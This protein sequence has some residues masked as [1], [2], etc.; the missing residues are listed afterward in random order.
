MKVTIVAGAR[1][2]FI[3]VAPI[4]KAI[5]KAQHSGGQI[6]YRLVHTGQHYDKKMSSDFFEQLNIS[7]PDVN[8]EAGGGTQAEQTAAIMIRF[9]KELMENRPDIVLVVGDVT[10]TMA[11]A[12]TAKKLGI[13]VA[14]IE[15]GL[16][17]YDWTMPEEVNRIVTDALA[18]YFF[19]TSETAGE[20]IRK[21]GV[22]PDRIF[23]VGNTMI[24]TLYQNKERLQ[25]PGIWKDMALEEKSYFIVTLHRPSNVDNEKN[26]A[27]I[28][29]TILE[30]TS[31]SPVLFPV[32]PRTKK[33]LGKLQFQNDR[34]V[35]LDPLPYLEFVYLIKNAR[36]VIT[37]SGGITEETTVLGVPCITLRNS[38]ER[39]ETIAIGTNE[40]AGTNPAALSKYLRQVVSG[41][42]KRG[43]IPELWDGKTS[44]RIVDALSSIYEK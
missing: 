16:R 44:E 8:L 37:D 35:Q 14:H 12:I 31:E 19:T 36:A 6:L 5:K 42:W 26:L 43:S 30:A 24:D 38:T 9:E 25:M 22:N 23:F 7:E 33:I 41:Q 27:I 21:Q 4:I 10:S 40:L 20:N 15:A 3:K 29:N 34:L 2:N 32:H 13:D 39:P 28:L 18:D 17:S 1:P 11:C